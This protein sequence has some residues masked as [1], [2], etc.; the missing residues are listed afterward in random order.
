MEL[1]NLQKRSI[2]FLKP[3]SKL[4][5]VNIATFDKNGNVIP[6]FYFGNEVC[7]IIK[8]NEIGCSL[9]DNSHRRVL[10]STKIKYLI[11]KELSKCGIL[12]K[13]AKN[14]CVIDYCDAGLLKVLYPINDKSGDI[15]GYSGICGCMLEGCEDYSLNKLKST[16]ESMGLDGDKLLELAKNELKS[17]NEKEINA[18][19]EFVGNLV[20]SDVNLDKFFNTLNKDL[21]EE[22]YEYVSKFIADIVIPI[23]EITN[24]NLAI[25]DEN[26]DIL[27]ITGY[28]GFGDIVEFLQNNED[29]ITSLKEPYLYNNIITLPNMHSFHFL[30]C[31]KHGSKF[32]INDIFEFFRYLYNIYEKL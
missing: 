11:N 31:V 19:L 14:K 13:L 22:D 23:G 16:A 6:P 8:T 20:V 32:S 21:T 9:C 25:L 5:N 15:I 26:L 3:L 7:K 10:T 2:V 28:Y 18:I 27:F 29:K 1:K 24:T 4:F 30:A 12:R 17:L